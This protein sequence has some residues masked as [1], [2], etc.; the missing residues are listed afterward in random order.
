ML[1]R[2][3]RSGFQFLG[4]TNKQSVAEHMHRTAYVGYVLAKIEDDPNIDSGKI[5]QMCLLHDLAEARTSDLNWMNQKYVTADEEKAIDDMAADLPFG[6]DLKGI[7]EEYEERKSKEAVLAKDADSLELLLTL[8][9]MI[10]IGHAKAE[11]WI[12]SLLKRMKTKSAHVLA[13]K[14]LETESD[15]WWY[16]NKDDEYWVSRNLASK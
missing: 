8:K 3:P 1:A 11:T 7:I 2:V 9:E 12:P 16:E 5:M 4:G 15:D 13:Q 14:I 10:D 6:D